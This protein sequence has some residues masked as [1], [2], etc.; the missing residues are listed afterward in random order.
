[1]AAFLDDEPPIY[2]AK[3]EKNS[4]WFKQIMRAQRQVQ[5]L[6]V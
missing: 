3:L 6:K 5:R 1:M 2:Q 4:E